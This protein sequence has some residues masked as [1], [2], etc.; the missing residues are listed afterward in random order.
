MNF[1][2]F[3]YRNVF[4][5]EFL[6]LFF[7]GFDSLFSATPYDV[8]INEI[9]WMGTNSSSYDEWIE[10]Y[11]NTDSP[12]NLSG[13]VLTSID[14]TP[15]INLSGT[16][17]AH[18][19]FLLE[20]TDDNTVSD[21]SADQIYTGALN[22]GGEYLQLKDKLGQIID[23]VDC[24]TGWF[25]GD[26]SSKITME[27]LNPQINGSASGNWDSNNGLTING[28]DADGNPINGTPKAQNSVYDASLPVTLSSFSAVYS[29]GTIILRWSTESE[30]GIRG[31]N[32]LRSKERKKPFHRI[33]T[34]LITAQGNNSAGKQYE[35]VDRDVESNK[36]YWYKIEIVE[37]YGKNHFL[38]PISAK[39]DKKS[40]LVGEHILLGNYPNPFNPKTTIRYSIS[41]ETALN[42][43]SLKIYNSLGKKI[44]TLV[45]GF[46]TPG[47]YS[48]DWDGCDSNGIEVP[49]GIYFY[50]LSSGCEIIATKRMLKI[51]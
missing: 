35:Y 40:T 15:N 45:K 49:S 25:A 41:Q 6:L 10:L 38:G 29:R 17:P 46:Q 1:S 50:Q 21:I 43:I 42:P 47:Y 8:V 19:Y 7:G 20:R 27:R 44:L 16:I 48:V 51:K 31:F 9:A 34:A 32:V 37:M 12:V 14:G 3:H 39:T 2:I 11:N 22:D 36:V 23:E 33:T 13:W 26:N 4:F 24:A 28:K 18:G 30:V 5:I